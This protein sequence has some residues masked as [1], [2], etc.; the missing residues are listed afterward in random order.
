MGRKVKK[1]ARSTDW[2]TREGKIT[3]LALSIAL[4]RS[5]FAYQMKGLLD[6]ITAIDN[7]IRKLESRNV[8]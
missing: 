2:R 3:R 7:Q 5:N 8:K 6:D 4:F 1:S